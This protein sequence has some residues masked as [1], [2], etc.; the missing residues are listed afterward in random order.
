MFEQQ[1]A[2]DRNDIGGDEGAGA[3]CRANNITDANL[4]RR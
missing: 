2:V 1:H 4:G 3:V